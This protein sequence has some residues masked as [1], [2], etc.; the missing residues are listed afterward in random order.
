MRLGIVD[1]V[2]LNAL[3]IV[4]LPSLELLVTRVPVRNP[5]PTIPAGFEASIYKIGESALISLLKSPSI[6]PLALLSTPLIL[7]YLSTNS[8]SNPPPD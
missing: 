7:L 6:V 1:F 2:L 5:L 4:S 8:S 3:A